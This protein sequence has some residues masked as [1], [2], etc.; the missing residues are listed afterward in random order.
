M[1]S[2][3]T[4]KLFIAGKQVRPDG[5]YSLPVLTSK[6][7]N[8]RR[9][10][11]GQPQGHPRRCDSGARLQGL[12]EATAYNRAQVLYYL[13]ENLSGRTEEFAARIAELT[14]A[15]HK[16]AKAEVEASIE[17]LFYYAGMTD[18]FEGRVHQPPARTVTLALHEPVGVIGI[19]PLTIHALRADLAARPALAMG[20]TTVVVPSSTA[21]LV[22]TDLYQVLEYS[23]V[24]AGAINIVTGHTAELA[25]VLAKHDDVDGLWVVAEAEI[26]AKAEAESVGNLKRVWTGRPQPRLADSPGRSL[27]PPCRRGQERLG[28]IRRLG[29]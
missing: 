17:R 23:D 3:R 14:G 27:P 2:T 9:G 28:P 26:C 4:A 20:N 5:N 24:P 1:A 12:P 7:K 25:A 29:E 15:G 13:A 18:K 6:G 10:R 22:A 19:V 21:P 8:S 11:L 16:A